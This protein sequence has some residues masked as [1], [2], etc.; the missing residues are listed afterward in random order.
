MTV[1]AAKPSSTTWN[2]VLSLRSACAFENPNIMTKRD[3][4]DYGPVLQAVTK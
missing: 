1:V 4:Y 3:L 2:R